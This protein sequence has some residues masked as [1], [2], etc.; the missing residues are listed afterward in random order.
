MAAAGAEP[1]G[2]PVTNEPQ[3]TVEAEIGERSPDGFGACADAT[4]PGTMS[5]PG[6][7]LIS[8]EKI[9]GFEVPPV[10]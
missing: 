6:K 5:H 1:F 9:H 7:P 4:V 10:A 3:K 2:L 8:I